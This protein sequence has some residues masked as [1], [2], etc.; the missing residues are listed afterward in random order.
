MAPRRFA[1]LLDGAYVLRR[2]R[3]TRKLDTRPEVG[4]VLEECARIRGHPLLQGLELLRVYWYDARPATS[5]VT[6]PVSR[7]KTHLGRSPVFHA[8]SSFLQ[9]LELERDMALRLGE[10]SVTS[11]WQLRQRSLGEL[12]ATGRPL[13]ADDLKPDIQQKGVDLRIGLDMARLALR[14]LVSTIVVVTGDSDMIP[15]F[16]F[17]RR[18]GIR[19]VLDD[20]GGPVKRE[21]RVHADRVLGRDSA[22]P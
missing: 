20:L 7:T 14:D 10:V 1:I 4:H 16:K 13:H 11:S 22:G 5:S 15:A 21:L 12:A 19:V 3:T 17:V 8:A 6:N 18:E 2:I 9:E